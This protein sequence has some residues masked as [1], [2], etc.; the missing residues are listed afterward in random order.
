MWDARRAFVVKK[1]E[2]DKLDLDSSKIAY[3]IIK[4]LL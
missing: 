4:I 1:G 2:K 3:V